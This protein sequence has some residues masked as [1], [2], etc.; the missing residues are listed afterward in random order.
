ME[1]LL[2][3][4]IPDEP[5]IIPK[6]TKLRV[7]RCSTDSMEYRKFSDDTSSNEL[8]HRDQFY[9]VQMSLPNFF[10]VMG[11]APY[12]TGIISSEKPINGVIWIE[13]SFFS[14]TYLIHEQNGRRKCGLV[15]RKTAAAQPHA[16]MPLF[17]FFL[18]P[19]NSGWIS[20]RFHFGRTAP[21][22]DRVRKTVMVKSRNVCD[23]I[24]ASMSATRSIN[25][26]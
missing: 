17:H 2:F 12:R 26:E 19:Q 6:A 18:P 24:I 11:G 9:N 1:S 23:V 13:G 25:A 3:W 16:C 20:T 15:I 7:I 8:D 10:S 4:K 21:S 22:R 14:K 5:R